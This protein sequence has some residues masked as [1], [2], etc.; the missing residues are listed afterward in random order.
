MDKSEQRRRAEHFRALHQGPRILLLGSVWD[1]G[2]AVVFER[3]GFAALGTSSAGIANAAGYPDGEAMPRAEMIDAVGRIAARVGIPVSADMEMGYGT[4][5][6]AVAET[7]RLVLEAGAVGV[8]LEDA[9]GDSAAPLVDVALQCEKLAAIRAMANAYGVPLVVNARTDGYWLKLWDEERR[10]QESIDRANAYRQAG[11][12]C[13]FV[14]G[15][16]EPTVVA[17]L[18]RAIAGP[19]NVLATPGCP[20]VGELERLGVRRVSQGSGP[21]R[22]AFATARAVAREL[23]QSGTYASYQRADLSYKDA[24]ALFG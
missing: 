17:T 19:L 4:T 24:N 23:R 12:D 6:E 20:E 10:L 14:P 22:A 2:S 11:A 5:P 7:C 8:N 1:V 9:T 3:E 18:A 13:L 21:A 16:V 15:A